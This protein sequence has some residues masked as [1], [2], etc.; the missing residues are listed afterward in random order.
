MLRAKR[1][2]VLVLSDSPHNLPGVKYKSILDQNSIKPIGKRLA[3]E[4]LS[5]VAWCC[6]WREATLTGDVK[7]LR[8]TLLEAL[9][10]K[11]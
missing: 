9:K 2:P 5:I 6:W 3:P 10:Q 8:E 1:R 4:A 7:N 11:E